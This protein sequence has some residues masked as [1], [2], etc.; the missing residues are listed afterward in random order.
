MDITGIFS[1]AVEY[2]ASDIFV[3][4]GKVPSFRIHGEVRLA[5]SCEPLPPSEIVAFRNSLLDEYRQK[6]YLKSSGADIGYE[7][8]GRRFRINFYETFCGP[9][10]VARP[11]KNG[12]D[13]T[14][15]RYKLPEKIFAEIA[16]Y[17]RGLVLISGS[18]GSGK[19]TTLGAVVNYINQRR[20]CHILTLE[21][22][23][24]FIHEDSKALISQREAGNI[25]GGIS[26]ALRDA[27]R[28][29]PDV[30]VVGE[31]RDA[32]TASAAVSSIPTPPRI[33][34]IF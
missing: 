11:V 10:F 33:L 19:S 32:E 29:N 9:A 22:P 25:A 8:G 31:I 34:T 12:A 15:E 5:E 13:C 6:E 7:V 1:A 17:Q 23:V 30:I 20:N 28:E 2:G 26:T 27:L 14:F 24:E 3:T 16:M 18:T 4:S 21:D